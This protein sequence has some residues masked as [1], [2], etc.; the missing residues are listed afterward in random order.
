MMLRREQHTVTRVLTRGAVALSGAALLLFSGN[1]VVSAR[2]AP[3]PGSASPEGVGAPEA[4]PQADYV[5][6]PVEVVPPAPRSAPPPKAAP[7]HGRHAVGHSRPNDVTV[8]APAGG[9]RADVVKLDPLDTCISCT[10]AGAGPHGSRAGAIALRL[11][12]NDISAGSSSSTSSNRGALIAV[13]AKGSASPP[14]TT[15]W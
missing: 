5:S 1:A 10:A 4:P 15:H 13:P 11:L 8:P 14:S 3:P 6:V 9:A 2:M 12:G 7:A